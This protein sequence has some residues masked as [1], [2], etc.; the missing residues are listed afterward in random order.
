MPYKKSRKPQA[1][2]EKLIHAENWTQDQLAK[3]LGCSRQTAARK[4]EDPQ[5]LTVGDLVALCKSGHIPADTIRG[6]I[7]F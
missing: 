4:T 3:I 2:L 5:K 7:E 1:A 6:S